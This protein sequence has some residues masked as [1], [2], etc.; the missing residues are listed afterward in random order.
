[1]RGLQWIT[2]PSLVS[3]LHAEISHRHAGDKHN[4][5]EEHE[6]TVGLVLLATSDQDVG[7]AIRVIFIATIVTP[8]DP[9][10]TLALNAAVDQVVV[11]DRDT[12]GIVR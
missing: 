5:S 10:L 6:R 2:Y 8:R 7:I 9:V 3:L 12:V 4:E 11:D 1:V